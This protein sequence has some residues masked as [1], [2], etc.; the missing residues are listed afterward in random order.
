[1]DGLNTYSEKILKIKNADAISL[2]LSAASL[3]NDVAIRSDAMRKLSDLKE[4][5]AQD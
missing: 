2:A 3:Q 5:S 1:V 4:R